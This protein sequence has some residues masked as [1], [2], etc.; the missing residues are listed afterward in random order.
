MSKVA[1]AAALIC[2]F[3]GAA[4]AESLEDAPLPAAVSLVKEDGSFKFSD[5]NGQSLYTSDRDSNGHSS[6][7]GACA[8]MW[9]PV[10]APSDAHRIGDWTPIKRTDNSLQW[11]YKD[12]PVYTYSGDKEPGQTKGVGVGGVWHLLTP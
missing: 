3:S 4:L 1:Y 10:A 6:C 2:L 8:S 9:P 5:D 7:D 11:A 12:R